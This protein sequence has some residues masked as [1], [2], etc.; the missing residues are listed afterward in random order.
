MDPPFWVCLRSSH[1]AAR[2]ASGVREGGGRGRGI[3]TSRLHTFRFLKH[4]AGNLAA[5]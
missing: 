4:T 1:S 3:I 2:A 5:A